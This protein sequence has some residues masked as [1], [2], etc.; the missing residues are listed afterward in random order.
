MAGIDQYTKLLL[1]CDG[2]DASTTFIDSATS[3]TIT[4][5]NQAQVDTAQSEFGGASL[6]VDGDSDYLTAADSDDFNMGYG[7]CT[8]DFWC[9]PDGVQ[10]PLY[11]AMI[12]NHNSW[13]TGSFGIRYDNSGY[14]KKF[15]V[16][17]N[18]T[19]PEIASSTHEPNDWYHIAVTRT[20]TSMILYV[21]G[22]NDGSSTCG[23]EEVLDL[24][25]YLF[26]VGFGGW[27]GANGYFKGWIDEVRISKGIVRW[28]ANFTPPTQ[29]Y[30]DGIFTQTVE[31]ILTLSGSVIKIILKT[32]T[33]IITFSGT[34]TKIGVFKRTITGALVLTGSILKAITKTVVGVLILSGAIQKAISKFPAGIIVL[35]GSV[36]KGINQAVSGIITFTGA[37]VKKA[38]GKVLTGALVLTG[39]IT[40][41]AI[42]KTITGALVLTGYLTKL[43]GMVLTGTIIFTGTIQKGIG[44]FL[45]G[46]LTFVGRLG[47][48]GWSRVARVAATWTALAKKSSIWTTITKKTTTWTED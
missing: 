38:I 11:P 41:K 4:T 44:K 42:T 33:G 6:L 19:D 2:A 5:V 8:I 25:M 21:N 27:D 15:T 37:I 28:T 12:S 31:G 1:H 40:N 24:S 30:N 3:K 45:S 16:H 36:Y 18:P 20:G 13:G 48:A 22:V 34:L 32:I 10:T 17:W 14:D 47:V 26:Y 39:A 9:M 46:T 35:T 43:S 23:A 7:D 29:A